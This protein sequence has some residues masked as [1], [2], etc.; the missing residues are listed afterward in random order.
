MVVAVLLRKLVGDW[1]WLMLLRCPVFKHSNRWRDAEE[2]VSHNLFGI[3]AGT[4]E[5]KRV[6]SKP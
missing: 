6:R 2:S 1:S 4:D 3:Y 5:C